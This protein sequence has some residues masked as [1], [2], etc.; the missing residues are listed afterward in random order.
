MVRK[1]LPL[2]FIVDDDP[3][4]LS[5]I[6]DFLINENY[7]RIMTFSSGK[8]CLKAME[9]EPEIVFLDH[10]MDIMNG[11]EVLKAIHNQFPNTAVIFLSAQ[12]SVKVALD[13]LKYG[14]YD[15]I[16]KGDSTFSR[17]KMNVLK[18]RKFNKVLRENLLFKKQKK[19]MAL[20]FAIF[21]L[22]IVA[23]V[24]FSGKV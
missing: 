6:A 12:E 11:I 17:I 19:T 10:N 1:G 9:Q 7:T 18:V 13:A 24:L 8:D 20:S 5:M 3:V 22:L 14:A 2:I 4:Y 23:V 15:Y 16:I 21:I